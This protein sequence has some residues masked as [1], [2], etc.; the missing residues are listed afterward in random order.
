MFFSKFIEFNELFLLESLFV[1]MNSGLTFMYFFDYF[2]QLG[3][4]RA[5]KNA[6][7]NYSFF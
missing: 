1:S 3:L 6:H 4:E 7:L 5:S 2:N